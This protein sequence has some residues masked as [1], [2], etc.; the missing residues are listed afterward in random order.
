[1]RKRAIFLALSVV[2]F[3]HGADLDKV[4]VE[5][6][7]NTQIVKDVTGKEIKTADLAE[8]L[9]KNIP[10]VNL[11]RRSGIANDILLRGQKR[12][13][14]NVIIDGTKVCGACVNRM[15]PPTSH[16]LANNIETVE[17]TEGPF[18]VENFGTLSG[19][20]KIKTKKPTKELSG[21]ITANAG[22]FGYQKLSGS[23][24]GGN[25]RIKVLVS[26]STEKGEQ[27]EDGNGD[28]F[29]GQIAKNIA[30]GTVPAIA[31]YQDKY[32][33]MDAFEKST[34][35]GKIFVD[36]TDN[37]ELRLSYTA[38]RSDDV[39]YPSS[40]MDAIYDDS[41]IYNLEYNINNLGTYSKT[42]NFQAYQSEVDH[43]MGTN[44]RVM[45]AKMYKI[46]A[47]TTKMQGVK[48]KNS[49]DFNEIEYTVGIDSSR[50]N[51]D[52]HFEVNGKPVLMPNGQL[53]K[54][55]D[56][57]DTTNQALFIKTK[58]S[59][60]IT[61][62]EF[63]IRYDD[64]T[65]E[66][67]SAK[68][69]DNDYSSL[70]G[71]IFA[72]IHA[73]DTLTYFA[74]I[75]KSSR[76]PDPRELYLIMMGNHYGTP[77][78]ND[79]ENYE[80]D[81]GFEKIYGDISLKT[82]AYYSMLKDYIAY[83]SSNKTTKPD[84]T[85]GPFHAFENVDAAIYGL[86]IS[87]NYLATDSLYLN[88]GIS[89]KRGKKDDPLQGQSGTDLA[90]MRPLKANVAINYDNDSIGN[91]KLE[92]VGA[93]KWTDIDYEN[94]EQKLAGYGV[95]N[96]KLSRDFKYGITL[97]AGIDNILDKTYAITNTYKDLVLLTT[98][99]DTMLLNE[100]GRYFYLNGSYKF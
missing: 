72:T 60:G 32:K 29:V 36:I 57:V 98:G 42:L 34:F 23:A 84:G 51:W 85:K 24:S 75:G 63:G 11:I 5:E 31:Q 38:N 53:S 100:P 95:L 26:A 16:V 17:V 99:T 8:D 18:D 46:H 41:D 33:N 47:L 43:P 56:D 22:S 1:M 87:G 64:T 91:A 7:I 96:L 80:I 74:G 92:F 6:T 12:D 4:V 40:K 86:E 66:S 54:S 94:G 28:D 21:D 19:L 61:D 71:N 25:D 73:N 45:G 37:Q 3:V 2:P 70:T 93:D 83:N 14:I 48:L 81:L 58:H 59:Y 65:I 90:D 52:G 82:K 15:D 69:S 97:T 89:Y 78:L 77:T 13:N 39:L 49:F 44:Y 79:T 35:M 20:V 9:Q 76:V 55:L 30:A 88:Y 10:S 67:A 68:E 62:F 27:Y 50:R